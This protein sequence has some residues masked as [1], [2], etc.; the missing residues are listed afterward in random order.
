M[1]SPTT[2]RR[3]QAVLETLTATG[4]LTR[5]SRIGVVV[6]N[7]PGQLAGYQ[8][9]LLPTARRLG[10]TVAD[11]QQLSCT[12]GFAAAGAQASALQNAQLRFHGS[13]VDRVVIVSNLEA[14]FL[15]LF[16][17]AA[18][19]QG[20]RPGYALTSAAGAALMPGNAPSAQV[21]NMRVAGWVPTIDTSEGQRPKPTRA[22]QRCLRLA[23]GQGLTPTSVTDEVY[24]A[25]VCDS[26]FLLEAM[27]R[28]TRGSAARADL[29]AAQP[30][31]GSGYEAA[32]TLGGRTLLSARHDSVDVA[33]QSSFVASCACFRYTG[34][35]HRF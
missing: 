23:K 30:A 17:Q 1:G 9:G 6:E 22:Y 29:M 19:S 12:S 31:I 5:S 34:P 26:L 11:T 18:E 16:A 14:T 8:R 3:E 2:E 24:L 27:L 13:N 21:A 10:L 25:M 32:S 15:V 7:C 33:R 28:T 4:W 35:A 20:Y